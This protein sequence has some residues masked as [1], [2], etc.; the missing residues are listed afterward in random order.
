MRYEGR[1]S[2][3]VIVVRHEQRM[4]EVKCN[5]FIATN[6]KHLNQTLSLG[7]IKTCGAIDSSMSFLRN[8]WL[9]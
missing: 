9:A 6:N 1:G 8:P 5:N 2:N 7:A 3:T 4:S